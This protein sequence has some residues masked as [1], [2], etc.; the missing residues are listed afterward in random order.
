MPTRIAER[1]GAEIIRASP[2]RAAERRAEM[3]QQNLFSAAELKAQA[4]E[5]VGTNAEPFYERALQAIATLEPGTY[6]GEDVRLRIVQIL[7]DEPHHHNAWGAIISGAVRRGY[8]VPTGR[9]LPMKTAKSHARKTP[10]YTH[11]EPF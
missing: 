10:E 8:L 1:S 6:T 7:Q 11:E 4:L 3:S 5:Q 9:Y 2:T